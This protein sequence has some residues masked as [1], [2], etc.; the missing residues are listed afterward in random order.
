MQLQENKNTQIENQ[1]I[2]K[3]SQVKLCNVYLFNI[4]L[5]ESKL[6]SSILFLTVEAFRGSGLDKNL[7][8]PT[9]R[10]SNA[11]KKLDGQML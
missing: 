1:L 2:R 3:L 8:V 11:V 4:F 10:V 5:V 9:H 6:I 7:D